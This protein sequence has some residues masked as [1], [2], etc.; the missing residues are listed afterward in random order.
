MREKLLAA[1]VKVLRESYPHV[2]PENIMTDRIYR[3]FFKASLKETM[4]DCAGNEAV[5][6]ECRK[7]IAEIDA[8]K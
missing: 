2:T 8:V 5:E 1:G 7:L 6:R 3:A 4:E